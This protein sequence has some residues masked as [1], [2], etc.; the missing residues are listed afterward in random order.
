MGA[1][2]G[3]LL[4]W[5]AIINIWRWFVPK[6]SVPTPAGD[7]WVATFKKKGFP[8]VTVHAA[9]EGLAVRALIAM[10]IDYTTIKQ[11]ERG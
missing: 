2:V 7:R 4:L 1:L 10:K 8:P 9:S 5:I 11:L 3:C 6:A